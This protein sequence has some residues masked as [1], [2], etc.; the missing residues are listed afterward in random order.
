MP[1]NL[2]LVHWSLI[3]NFVVR[4]GTRMLINGMKF[5]EF[6]LKLVYT[7]V[8]SQST[9][10]MDKKITFYNTPKISLG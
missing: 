7:D 9:Q 5:K 8:L 4:Y 2:I 1:I 6:T 3:L 10:N